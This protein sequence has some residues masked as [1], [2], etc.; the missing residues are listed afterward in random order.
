MGLLLTGS[1]LLGALAGC[2]NPK[3]MPA[4]RSCMAGGN[5]AVSG[6]KTM[7]EATG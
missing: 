4:E 2:F 1:G 3:L 5:D 6:T 7:E